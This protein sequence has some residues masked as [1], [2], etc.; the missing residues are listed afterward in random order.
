[1]EKLAKLQINSDDKDK[2]IKVI[3]NLSRLASKYLLNKNPALS[4]NLLLFSHFSRDSR[5]LFNLFRSLRE[6]DALTKD[7]NGPSSYTS[8]VTH[9]SKFCFYIFDNINLLSSFHIAPFSK[10]ITGHIGNFFLLLI[11]LC[12]ISEILTRL[13]SLL[14]EKKKLSADSLSLPAQSSSEVTSSDTEKIKKLDYEILAQF[15]KLTA[16]IADLI[17]ILNNSGILRCFVGRKVKEF[18]GIFCGMYSG[19]VALWEAYQRL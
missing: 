6:L 18:I 3:Q 10:R 17:S 16:K 4:R 14:K 12:A 8:M 1:M 11:T 7:F 2:F 9:F 5:K 19:T 15:V 13:H